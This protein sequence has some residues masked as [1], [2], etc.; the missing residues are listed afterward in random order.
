M[1]HLTDLQCSMYVDKALD[2]AAM[3]EVDQHLKTCDSCQQQLELH[4]N[5]QSLIV[6]AL[7]IGEPEPVPAMKMPKFKR[8]VGLRELAIANLATGGL[9]WLIQ[10]SWKTLFGDL[11]MDSFS[12]LTSL[13]VPDLYDLS[14][15]TILYLTLEGTAMIESYSAVI[16]IGVLGVGLLT[17]AMLYRNTRSAMSFIVLALVAGIL[18]PGDA[19]AIEL[20]K[21]DLIIEAGEKLS[22]TLLFTGESLVINGTV[23]GDVI[24]FGRRVVI[25]GEVLG[26]L[27][28]FAESVS[29]SG[30]VTGTTI[31]AGESV[32]VNDAR[33]GGDIWSAGERVKLDRLTRVIGNG[34][35]AGERVT[36]DGAIGR[37]LLTAT[38]T[39]ELS[40]TVGEDMMAYAGEVKLMANASVAGN[41]AVHARSEKALKQ[42]E[43]ATVK[44]DISFHSRD[45]EN[46]SENRF[47]SMKFYL[48]QVL[49][50]AAAL[51]VGYGLLML[52]PAMRDVILEGG[53]AGLATAGVGL[54]ALVSVPLMMVILAFTVI[55]LPLSMIGFF[56]WLI[57]LYIAKILAAW[58]IGNLVINT[59]DEDQEPVF[60]P[61][62]VGLGIVMI[63]INLPW[64]GGFI[65]LVLSLLGLGMLVQWTLRNYQAAR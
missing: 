21:D 32:D 28:V 23:E 41:L 4:R 60:L 43:T 1:T 46:R 3:A 29:I 62:L 64:I 27:I 45:I 61:L 58:V 14:V 6:A 39:V 7:A 17:I 53:L 19:M 54:V 20:K 16:G 25:D 50:I 63:V 44:G 22:D 13:M 49:R 37:D 57:A 18:A 56:G 36:V 11:L 42:S 40:G 34:M 9:F 35:L 38:E 47:T 52:F 31:S 30:S 51:L 15:S 12:W 55:G 48:L 26:N 24:A 33:L 65:S 5:D 2:A 10:F 8:S 59:Q